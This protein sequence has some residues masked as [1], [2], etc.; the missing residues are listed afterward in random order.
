M[1]SKKKWTR[2]KCKQEALK[3]KTPW[4]WGKNHAGSYLASKKY[5]WHPYCT[6]HMTKKKMKWL[7]KSL[8]V[9]TNL[10]MILI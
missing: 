6:A 9:F 5:G 3:Y 4:E 10:L 8:V 1:K 7:E 2:S